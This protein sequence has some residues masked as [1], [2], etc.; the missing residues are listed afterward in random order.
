MILK[1][2]NLPNIYSCNQSHTL[3]AAAASLL[4]SVRCVSSPPTMTQIHFTLHNLWQ[5]TLHVKYIYTTP[6]KLYGGGLPTLT[7]LLTKGAVPPLG[8]PHHHSICLQ[9]GTGNSGTSLT[10]GNIILSKSFLCSQTAYPTP[11][12][13]NHIYHISAISWLNWASGAGQVPT[14]H[15]L[16][17][18]VLGISI[19]HVQTISPD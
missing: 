18:T 7:P 10:Y 11:L 3:A 12:S 17:L 4:T 2:G 19:T 1:V 5:P 14:H 15:G 16:W 13:F 8:P 9:H 6:T